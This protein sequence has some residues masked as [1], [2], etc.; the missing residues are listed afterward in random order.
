MT[1]ASALIQAVRDIGGEFL[2]TD[3]GRIRNNAGDAALQMMD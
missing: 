1:Q 2:L 3:N